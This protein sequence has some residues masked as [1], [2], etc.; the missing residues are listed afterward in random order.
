MFVCGGVNRRLLIFPLA[1]IVIFA[2]SQASVLDQ[3][4]IVFTNTTTVRYLYV[5]AVA[6]CCNFHYLALPVV[7]ANRTQLCSTVKVLIT[8]MRWSLLHL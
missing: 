5:E 4:S 3:D 7:D 1:W 2:A 6:N 8:A